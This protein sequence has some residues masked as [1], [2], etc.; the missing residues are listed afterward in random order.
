MSSD[1]AEVPCSSKKEE[2]ESVRRYRRDGSCLAS[3]NEVSK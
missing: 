2:Y 3:V 1:V